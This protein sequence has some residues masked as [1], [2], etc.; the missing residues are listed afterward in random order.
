MEIKITGTP[1]E[2]KKL[3]YAI[4]SSKE[5]FKNHELRIEYLERKLIETQMNYEKLMTRGS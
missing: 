4:G 3:L 5:Q 1:G 2:I